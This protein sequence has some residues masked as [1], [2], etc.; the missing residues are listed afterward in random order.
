MESLTSPRFSPNP[1]ALN[2]FLRFTFFSYYLILALGLSSDPAWA[3]SRRASS[4]AGKNS[5]PD[6]PA[7]E[8]QLSLESIFASGKYAQRGAGV[9]ESLKDGI[10]YYNNQ[11]IGDSLN[12]KRLAYLC[13]R[14][15][16]SHRY[17]ASRI[18]VTQPGIP[19]GFG[20]GR[21]GTLPG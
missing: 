3:Q 16:E 6:A 4:G 18:L 10:H 17:P 19:A 14:R 7:A 15:R 5:I 20:L 11:R 2:P 1:Y 21:C 9:M 12:E 13:V 8:D